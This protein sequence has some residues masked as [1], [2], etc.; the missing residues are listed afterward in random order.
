MKKLWLVGS[1]SLFVIGGVFVASFFNY[2]FSSYL[3]WN[4]NYIWTTFCVF[5]YRDL[6]IGIGLI[7][8]GVVIAVKAKN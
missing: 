6:G 5:G 2:F 7:I 8:A 3:C 4:W 1:V